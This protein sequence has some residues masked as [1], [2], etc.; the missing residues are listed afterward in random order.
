MSRE[1]ILARAA[2]IIRDEFDDDSLDITEDTVA[3][4][5]EEWDSLAQLSI[6]HEVEKV[7]RIH[8]SIDEIK[9]FGNVGDMISCISKHMENA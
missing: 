9:S 1:E 6:V 4:D 2:E 3:A 7:F 8:F 5:V